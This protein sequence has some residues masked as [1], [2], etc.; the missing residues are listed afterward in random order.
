[1]LEPGHW[2]LSLTPPRPAL[3]VSSSPTA[4]SPDVPEEGYVETY[5][6]GVADSAFALG[7]EVVA[8]RQMPELNVRL[9]KTA[10]FHVRGKVV[11]ARAAYPTKIA[12]V[13]FAGRIGRG[14]H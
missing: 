14:R 9:R 5:Y 12:V 1:M 3:H 4:E 10:V 7:L 6:P 8:G 11:G 13:R 2:Y